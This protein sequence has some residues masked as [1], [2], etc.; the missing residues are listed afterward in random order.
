MRTRSAR[1]LLVALATLPVGLLACESPDIARTSAETSESRA[2]DGDRK[3]ERTGSLEIEVDSPETASGTATRRIEAAGGFI[4]HSVAN[5]DGAVE[6]RCRV[7]E[8]KLDG[9]MESLAGLGHVTHRSAT[10]ADVTDEHADLATR[11]E[12]NR[13]LRDRLQALLD[14]ADT[15][16]EVLDI[17]RELNR[18]QSEIES[19]QGRLDRLES[20]V[21]MSTLY[22]SLKRERVLGPLGYVAKG[23]WWFVSKLFVLR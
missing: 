16:E 22:V 20:R 21:A 9:L 6:I 14:R 1:I 17:E 8:A 18:V 4:E 7:P 19:Q 23:V 2:R 12:N 15:V 10:A 11:L 3:V 13:E 5:S